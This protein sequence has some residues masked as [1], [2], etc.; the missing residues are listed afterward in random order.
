MLGAAGLRGAFA[1][2]AQVHPIPE[3][4]PYSTRAVAPVP[5]Y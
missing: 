2:H 1:L 5:A 3:C 4:D